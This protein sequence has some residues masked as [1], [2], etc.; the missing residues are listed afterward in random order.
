MSYNVRYKG[1][2]GG[3]SDWTTPFYQPIRNGEYGFTAQHLQSN[4][5]YTIISIPSEFRVGDVVDFQ[6]QK[7]E[8]YYTSWE[9]MLAIVMGT[10][11]FTGQ[12][13]EWSNTQTITIGE[14]STSPNPTQSSTNT[15]SPTP[16]P[17]IPE[18]TVV[19]ILPLLLAAPLITLILLRKKGS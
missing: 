7:L 15:I 1:H 8:G 12:Y 14:T 11:Q 19:A 13:S 17:T 10:S 4:S 6:V 5:G 16:T 2:F 3:E 18:Y 9:P